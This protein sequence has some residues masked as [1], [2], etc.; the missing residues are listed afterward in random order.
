MITAMIYNGIEKNDEIK[1]IIE[2]VNPDITVFCIDFDGTLVKI[3]KSPYDVVVSDKL[4]DFLT[5]IS[6]RDGVYL[7]IVTGRELSDIENRIG[8]K[9]NIIY[10]GNHG[11]EIK[12][13][14]KHFKLDFLTENADKY[15]PLLTDILGKVKNIRLDNLILENK[16]FSIS[17]HYRL[18]DNDSAKYLKKEVKDILNGNPEFKKYL[19]IARGKKILEIRPKIDWNK[20]SAC[21]YITKEL[22]ETDALIPHRALNRDNDKVNILKVSLGDDVTDETMFYDDYSFTEGNIAADIYSINCVI[23]KKK[24]AANFYI[25]NY[26]HTPVFIK[27]I[28]TIFDKKHSTKT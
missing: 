8:I 4:R 11:F 3:C 7:C 15:V 21:K 24:S 22:I 12:S 27:E 1:K 19:H 10:S 18:L 2:S 16:K 17:I 13:Y 5:D 9:N 26:N 25:E 14:Y 6:N 20:G 28:L 23:G